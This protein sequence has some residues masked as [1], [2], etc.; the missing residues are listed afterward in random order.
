MEK[1]IHTLFARVRSLRVFESIPG[2]ST[3][4]AGVVIRIDA[5]LAA[6]LARDADTAEAITIVEVNVHNGIPD[7]GVEHIDQDTLDDVAMSHNADAYQ[8][9]LL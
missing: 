5:V 9:G 7:N 3:S 2:R 8:C 1:M 4:L 6:A